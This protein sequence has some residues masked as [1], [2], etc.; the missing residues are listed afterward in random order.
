M[1]HTIRVLLVDDH[2]IFRKGLASLL[3][4]R[5]D[6]ELLA[7]A[8]TGSEAVRKAREHLPDLILMDIYMPEMDGLDATRQIKE[9]MPSTKIVMLTV[10]EEDHNLF[11][12]IK[13]G[14]EGYLIKNVKPQELFE[15]L[16]GVFRGEAPLSRPIA[17]KILKGLADEID[18]KLGP[19]RG[20]S[21]T[22]REREVLELVAR[23]HANKEIAA[24]LYIS[25][26]TVKKHLRNIL[27]KLHLENRVEAAVYALKKG[28]VSKSPA[29]GSKKE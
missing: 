14:A 24:A 6:F 28:I 17:T 25:E 29:S 11:E 4:E 1:E 9:E 2:A 15:M 27:E 19:V 10:S 16:R 7:E 22:H 12:A 20:P 13:G 18:R 3:L 23:G 21:I 5:S 8:E 26:S